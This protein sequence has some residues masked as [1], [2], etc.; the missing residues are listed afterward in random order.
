MNIRR[1]IREEMDDLQWI[2][3][4]EA[5]QPFNPQIGFTY[6]FKDYSRSMG[7][8]NINT[9]DIIIIAVTKDRVFFDTVDRYWQNHPD[10][11]GPDSMYKNNFN[12]LVKNGHIRY[13]GPSS[14][15]ESDEMDGLQWIKDIKPIGVDLVLNK[16][17]YFNRYKEDFDDNLY[18]SYYNVLTTRLVD[19][20]FEPN[21][22]TPIE[23]DHDS[24]DITGL[25]AYQNQDGD[26]AFVFTP[27]D[28][29]NSEEEYERHIKRYAEDESK[30]F[31]DNLEVVDAINFINTYL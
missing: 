14:I 10:D 3:D 12:R 21:Y 25:Y 16:A 31:G 13:I 9:D 23:A 11:E 8:E 20:G 6:R 30:D 28:E 26:L 24:F 17:F 2:K 29:E 7:Y 18:A 19:L 4:V 1:I 15:N 22:H 27:G 5:N